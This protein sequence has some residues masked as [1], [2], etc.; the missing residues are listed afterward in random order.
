MAMVTRE[1]N[2]I[3]GPVTS[4]AG[5]ALASKQ[6]IFQLVDFEKR[7]PVSLF[8][9]ATGGEEYVVGTPITATTDAVGVFSV[10]LWPNTRGE[11]ATLYKVTLPGTTIKP[12]YISVA[13]GAEPLTLIQAKAAVEAVAP[14]TLSLFEALLNNILEV[15][16][17]VTALVT[18]T[19]NGLMSF[20]DKVKLDA[21]TLGTV[22]A[23]AETAFMQGAQHVFRRGA[24]GG[25]AEQARLDAAGNL[26]LGSPAAITSAKLE[27]TGHGT[28]TESMRARAIAVGTESYTSAVAVN[29]TFTAANRH[30][31][32]DWSTLNFTDTGL[33]YASFDARAEMTNAQPEDHFVGFQ[34]RNVYNGA[35]GI[36]N[37]AHAYDAD[38]I[39]NGAGTIATYVGLKLKEVAG[40]G[41]IT[42]NYGV[43]IETQTKGTNRSAIYSGDGN[44]HYLG[45]ATGSLSTGAVTCATLRS[46]KGV[47]ASEHN[48]PVTLY[49]MAGNGI[50]LVQAYIDGADSAENYAAFAIIA[51]EGTT[52]RIVMQNNA[53]LLV[54]AL[55]G[56]D[57]R[58]TQTSTV[59]IGIT[60]VVAKIA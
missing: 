27:V 8:D 31:F 34:S 29:S 58:A 3:D 14:Q 55:S 9:A 12:F 40:T 48:T 26:L 35:G 32:E 7:Q 15:V 10:D 52:Q 56:A 28:F 19:V 16:G 2:N 20:T 25:Y 36:T 49:T 30:A 21:I 37:Y 17:T 4:P 38:F 53:A 45:G 46:A 50:Y 5:A 43:W 54:L 6:V 57:V 33:G 59:S 60:Y 11:R 23:G 13:E 1:L 44:H 47:I 51:K 39:H 22:D 41:T 18:T 24:V 42:N